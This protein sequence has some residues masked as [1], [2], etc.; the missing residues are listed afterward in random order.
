[1]AA[2]VQ[3]AWVDLVD[4]TSVTSVT[5]CHQE[6]ISSELLLAATLAGQ[7]IALYE[8]IPITIVR[9]L[10][11]PRTCS[12]AKSIAAGR[13]AVDGKLTT[14]PH[15]RKPMKPEA[16]QSDRRRGQLDQGTEIG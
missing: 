8:D 13:A 2:Q 3:P 7:V 1:M 12:T 11:L 6:G 14:W 4:I 16:V 9:T 10:S 5:A 15:T